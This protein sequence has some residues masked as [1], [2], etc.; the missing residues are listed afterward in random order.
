MP[1]LWHDS[2]DERI[3]I[4]LASHQR[5][6]KLRVAESEDV[7]SGKEYIRRLRRQFVQL[8]PTPDWADPE[9]NQQKN[10]SDAENMDTDD[11]EPSS[12]QPL[13]KLLQ[14]AT[15]LVKLEDKTAPGGRRK[16]RQEVVDIQR[17]KDVGKDQPVSP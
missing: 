6:R 16:L 1:A 13:A 15:D 17:L 11:E 12:T 9:K 4:S 2:D 8:N 14:N 7:I 3:S 5:L 10:D